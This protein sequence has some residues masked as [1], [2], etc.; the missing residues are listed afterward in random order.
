MLLTPSP[1]IWH[2]QIFQGERQLDSINSPPQALLGFFSCLIGYYTHGTK[3]KRYGRWEMHFFLNKYP[4]HS[5]EIAGFFFITVLKTCNRLRQSWNYFCSLLF[6]ICENLFNLTNSDNWIFVFTVGVVLQFI[7]HYTTIYVFCCWA[8]GWFFQLVRILA[9]LVSEW[10]ILLSVFTIQTRV[11]TFCS[12]S[13]QQIRVVLDIWP[14][15][16]P[17]A[18]HLL[19]E[20]CPT[21]QPFLLQF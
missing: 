13:L 14:Q 17:K 16:C 20:F 19:S 11:S 6:L 5:W 1:S 7:W 18:K 12:W 3:K 15:L 8:C 4:L 10:S 2:H 9:L 21:L